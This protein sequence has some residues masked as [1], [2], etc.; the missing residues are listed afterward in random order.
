[1]TYQLFPRQ[2]RK[3]RALLVGAKIPQN[4]GMEKGDPPFGCSCR[5]PCHQQAQSATMGMP[6]PGRLCRFPVFC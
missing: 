1:M 5:G 4:L 3:P 6:S 2:L